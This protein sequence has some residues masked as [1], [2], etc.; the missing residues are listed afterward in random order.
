VRRLA[1]CIAALLLAVCFATQALAHASLISVEPGDGSILA[2]A[3][4]RIQLR[5]N[6]SVTAGAV[7]LI[8]A[9]GR[10]RADAKADA[11]VMTLPPDLPRGSQIVSYR[12]ISQ[13]GH[14]VA[15]S[16][17]F[18]IGAPSAT[19]ER[20]SRNVKRDALIWLARI[21]FYV[22]LFAG[23]GGVFFWASSLRSWQRGRLSWARWR[24]AL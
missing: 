13:D 8:D 19:P 5:F 4:G 14:P 11:I 9:E 12:V 1:A 18:S 15:G 17:V 20:A 24:S 2:Q 21:G 23:V 3:L 6:E 22:G 10:L 16:V 7:T